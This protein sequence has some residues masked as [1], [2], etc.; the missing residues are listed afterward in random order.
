MDRPL[1]GWACCDTLGL[2][3][4]LMN[5]SEQGASEV[6][7]AW[8]SRGPHQVGHGSCLVSVACMVGFRSIRD[9]LMSSMG[10]MELR[11]FTAAWRRLA[12]PAGRKVMVR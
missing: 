12:F 5:G 11:A 9:G 2:A 4:A 1:F 6:D 7:R 8:S 10:F 3:S